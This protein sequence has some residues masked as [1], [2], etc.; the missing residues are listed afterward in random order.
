LSAGTFSATSGNLTLNI[1][2]TPTSSGTASFLVN[3]AGKTC[4]L[5]KTVA[6][7]SSIISNESNSLQIHFQNSV[8]SIEGDQANQIQSISAFD[9]NG[10]NVYNQ[11]IH[12]QANKLLLNNLL[13]NKGMYVLKIQKSNGESL[14]KK[15]II[16]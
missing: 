12:T 11:E 3:I 15:L 16:Q 4:T 14:S 13:L 1:T 9:L 2:G 7:G 10:R 8:L 6:V 5:T